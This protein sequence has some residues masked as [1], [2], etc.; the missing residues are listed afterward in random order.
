MRDVRVIGDTRGRSLLTLFLIV[1]ALLPL[2]NNVLPRIFPGAAPW[3]DWSWLLGLLLLGFYGWGFVY[4]RVQFNRGAVV[5]SFLLTTLFNLSAAVALMPPDRFDMYRFVILI[6]CIPLL[7]VFFENV[8]WRRLL[9][10][11][12]VAVLLL[13]SQWAIMQFIVQQDL[14]VQLLGESDISSATPGVAKFFLN[15]EKIVRAYGPYAH[16]NSLSAALLVG[17]ICLSFLWW[18]KSIV[19]TRMARMFFM[20]AGEVLM[21][22]ILLTFSRA[23]YVGLALWFVINGV[24]YMK[25]KFVRRILMRLFFVS[26]LVFIL[27]TPMLHARFFDP[28]GV[29]LSERVFG[30]ETSYAIIAQQP[31]WRGVGLG[32]YVPAL[33]DYLMNT[34]VVVPRWQLRPVHSVPILALAE[35]GWLPFIILLCLL[36][37][38]IYKSGALI[39]LLIPLLPLLLL[40]HYF[41]SQTAPALLLLVIFV[42]LT[43]SHKYAS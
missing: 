22:G 3:L 42:S 20:A 37:G 39:L 26:L 19:H 8:R 10:F 34:N 4:Q 6:W 38:T 32:M 5:V 17:L 24:L 33:D 29:A 16:S 27:F 14:G 43:M 15:G 21:F 23:A 35:L 9:L 18:D 7:V 11:G 41:Y 30:V 36:L 25:N 1:V 31:I 13:H 12:L 2:Q 40:D 28:E